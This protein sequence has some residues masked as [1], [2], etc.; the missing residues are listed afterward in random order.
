MRCETVQRSV[1]VAMDR[2]PRP[3]PE[4]R[5][6]VRTCPACSRFSARAWR[7]REL[8]RFEVAPPVPDLVPAIME[9][10]RREGGRATGR[11]GIG[12]P[13]RRRP[14]AL[15]WR[16]AAA[17]LVAGLVVGF[18]LTA[19]GVPR[20]TG[21]SPALAAEIP[22]RLQR[23]AQGLDGYRATFELAEANWHPAVPRRAF[24]AEV[25]FRSPES[26]RVEVEDLTDYPDS[27]WPR[28]DLL[29]VTDGPRYAVS[30]AARC[31]PAAVPACPPAAE[32]EAVAN[33]PPFDPGTPAPTDV[34]VP[35]TVL[36]AS[37][38][39]DVRGTDTVAG[40]E[41]VVVEL[42]FQDAVPL[43]QHLRV[44]GSWRPFFPQDR[45]LVSLDR[46]TWFP[47]R[48]EVFPADG[49]ERS[50]WAAQAGLP[51]E[52]PDVAV[53]RA[54]AR[55]LST[56]PPGPEAF[57]VPDDPG[58]SDGG[59]RDIPAAAIGAHPDTALLMPAQTEGLRA[60]RMGAFA[61]SESRTYHETVLAFSQGLRWL[62][63]TR[64]TGWDRPHPFGVGP[65]AEPVR[66]GPG[67]GYYEPA[68]AGTPRRLGLH[69]AH[70]EFLVA[71]DL[72]RASLLRIAATLPVE[73][74]PVPE[75]WRVRRSPVGRVEEGLSPEAALH[76]AGIQALLPAALPDRYRAVAAQVFDVAGSRGLTIAF[77]REAAEMDGVGIL[78][79]QTEGQHVLPPP[80]GGDEQALRVRGVQARWSPEEHLLEWI[81]DGR[82]VSL[83]GPSFDLTRLIAIAESLRPAWQ[84]RSPP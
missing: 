69:T 24:R 25:S 29:L 54:T 76:R 26:L 7:V 74:R 28:N 51:W 65:F 37:D 59:F 83:S 49:D 63:V 6:H 16:L 17:A 13:R 11:L 12:R 1:S 46:A 47:L 34:V 71:T 44:R 68:T 56:T 5:D 4:E 27:S 53:F 18:V 23:A 41:A 15:A 57:A 33:R 38:R 73:G 77:R 32:P 60:W 22:L 35:M 10:V 66:L 20:R 70:G 81:E 72:P 48:Y 9:S 80:T 79:S 58:A 50:L 64:V 14:D 52:D 61:T 19:G 2:G 30:G 3:S 62:T 67:V 39:V 45:V 84:G 43:F 78:L 40:R 42:A 31:S 21:L 82:Y 8:A 75:G 36:A 55:S